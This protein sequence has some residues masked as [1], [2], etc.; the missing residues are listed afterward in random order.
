MPST[1]ISL[2]YHIVFS[3]KER[4][5]SLLTRGA[6]NYMHTSA[7]LLGSLAPLRDRLAEPETTFTFWQD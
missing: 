7:V 3:T 6:T 2:H 1:H 5:D 4:R